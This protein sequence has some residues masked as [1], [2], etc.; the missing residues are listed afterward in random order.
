MVRERAAD[1]IVGLL[2]TT[3]GAEVEAQI[4][5]WLARQQLESM[6]ATAL[7]ILGRLHL[8]AGKTIDAEKYRAAIKVPSIVSAL[9]LRELGAKDLPLTWSAWHSGSAAVGFAVPEFFDRYK[10]SYL[11]PIYAETAAR[12]DSKLAGRFYRQWA[13]EWT[14]VCKRASIQETEQPYYFLPSRVEDESVV[15]DSIQSD[16]LRSAYVRTLAWAVDCA[17][18]GAGWAESR[19]LA[20]VPIDTAL[21]HVENVSPPPWWPRFVGPSSG[22][23]DRPGKIW[24]AVDELW[25]QSNVGS[26]I[27]AHASGGV[28]WD[29]QTFYEL[30]IHG[31][32]QK[33]TGPREA[34]ADQLLEWSQTSKGAGTKGKSIATCGELYGLPFEEHVEELNDWRL[35]PASVRLVT[36]ATPRW[37]AHRFQRFARVPAGFLFSRGVFMEPHRDS[38]RFIVSPSMEAGRWTTWHLAL[39]DSRVSAL[40]PATGQCLHL[41]RDSVR[42]FAQ[43]QSARFCWIA[44]LKVY[45]R[46]NTYSEFREMGFARAYGTGQIILSGHDSP[47]VLQ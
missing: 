40:P 13:Y 44:V 14:V 36:A 15:F 5:A 37:Q 42:A 11:P 25:N 8:E 34:T 18:M 41:V 32:F 23:D 9:L 6:A 46:P 19:A 16:A 17:G 47:S 38:L 30:E 20:T 24:S 4:E 3:H 21:W 12:A 33:A 31:A 10:A 39:R 35:V 28:S 22:V 27:I 45:E 7:V 1:Q 29:D 43:S 26:H 2:Q